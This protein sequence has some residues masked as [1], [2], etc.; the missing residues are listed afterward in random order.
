MYKKLLTSLALLTAGVLSANQLISVGTTDKAPKIDGKLNDGCYKQALPMAGFVNVKSLN[1]AKEQTEVRFVRDKE[2]LYCAIKA[3]QKNAAALP[4]LTPTQNNTKLWKYD[5]LEMFFLLGNMIRQYMFDYSGSSC[6]LDAYQNDRH[7]WDSKTISSK[8]KVAASRGKNF[9]AL[10]LAIPLDELGKGDIKFNIV[11][12]HNRKGHSTWARLEE[13]NWRATEKY[14]TLQMVNKV[15]ALKFD[16][17]PEL[18]LKSQVKMSVKSA[19]T[20]NVK[21]DA[22]GKVFS[23]SV[24]NG[25]VEFK[26]NL[27]ADKKSTN[28]VITCPRGKKLYDYT[29]AQPR[30]TLSIKPGN[31]TNNTIILDRGLQL[32]SRII[33]RSKHNLPNATRGQGYRVKIDNEIVFELPEGITLNK[34]KKVG[35]KIVDGKRTNARRGI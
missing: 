18:K 11:R 22:A 19:Q 24:T 35:E 29:Y 34:G 31:L 5:S 30:G 4:N 2:Y 7:T 32:E 10:E 6:V 28:L 3:F 16:I 21:F 8:V 1:Y 20:V 12:N 14:S 15:P 23:K 26:Y 33:W 9:W 13:I 27:P 17:L 25:V